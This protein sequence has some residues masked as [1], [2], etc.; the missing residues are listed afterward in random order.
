MQDP[1]KL[2]HDAASLTV[3]KMIASET[4]RPLE[5]VK[6]VYDDQFMRL[7]AGARIT[8]YLVLFATRRTYDALARTPIDA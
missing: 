6:R 7:K 1:H 5:E 8:D 3:I 2:N 4:H